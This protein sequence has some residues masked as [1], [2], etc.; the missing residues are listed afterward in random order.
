MKKVLSLVLTTLFTFSIPLMAEIRETEQMSDILQEVEAD[1]LVIFDV[2]YTLI[3]PDTMIFSYP[4]YRQ[5]S[6]TM[7]DRA[8][9]G[10]SLEKIQA[11]ICTVM[12]NTSYYPIEN[13]I[14]DTFSAITAIGAN[15][16]GLTGRPTQ[17]LGRIDDTG[18][19]LL[20]ILEGHNIRFSIASEI[21]T[22]VYLRIPSVFHSRPPIMYKNGCIFSANMPKGA[23]LARFIEKT[24]IEPKKVIFIDDLRHHVV[25]V[26]TELDKLDIPNVC[27][28]YLWDSPVDLAFDEELVSYQLNYLM[29]T[30]LW[31]PE[32]DAQEAISPSCEKIDDTI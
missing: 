13:D 5:L 4:G 14:A 12:D 26:A 2:D 22:D 31:L 17:P 11:W 20:E 18:N 15:T 23:V 32:K 1:T 29:D 24:G 10:I 25:S 8:N 9:D 7:I 30:D 28:H 19:F 16:M 3:H 6:N 21:P 27:F